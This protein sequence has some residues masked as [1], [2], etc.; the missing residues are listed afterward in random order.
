[1]EPLSD[2]ELKMYEVPGWKIELRRRLEAL[3]QRSGRGKREQ[4]SGGK[5]AK[6]RQRGNRACAGG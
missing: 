1:V 6:Q 5:Q 2:E 3:R 4:K